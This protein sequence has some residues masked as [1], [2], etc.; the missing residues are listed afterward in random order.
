ME[1]HLQNP[2][3]GNNPETFSHVQILQPV[4]TLCCQHTQEGKGE[5]SS[6]CLEIKGL[7]VIA[8]PEALHCVLE[9]EIILCLVLT[10]PHVTEKL[11]TGN[12]KSK[13]T[14][15]NME[16]ADCLHQILDLEPH[17]TATQH[18]VPL[19]TLMYLQYF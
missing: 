13:Q 17:L 11:L 6:A 3:F 5:Q 12:K 7:Q 15:T 9:Q 18:L 2:E 14:N 8:S 19:F 10:Q 1:S 16:A 4:K